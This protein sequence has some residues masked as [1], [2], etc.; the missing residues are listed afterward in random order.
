MRAQ[1]F[2]RPLLSCKPCRRA[3]HASRARRDDAAFAEVCDWIDFYYGHV[4]P[5][6]DLGVTALGCRCGMHRIFYTSLTFATSHRP[7][8]MTN[9]MPAPRTRLH[10]TCMAHIALSLER[11]ASHISVTLK[12]RRVSRGLYA[13]DVLTEDDQ[14][15]LPCIAIPDTLAISAALAGNQLEEQLSKIGLVGVQKLSAEMQVALFLAS[16]KDKG[17]NKSPQPCTVL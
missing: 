14:K 17:A 10:S 13:K 11:L 6:L 7:C 8:R 3:R 15:E 16:E 5:K 2:Q 9:S 4:H 12:L 1:S